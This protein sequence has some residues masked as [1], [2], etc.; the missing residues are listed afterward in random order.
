MSCYLGNVVYLALTVTLINI[1]IHAAML[2]SKR[3]Q[4]FKD[5]GM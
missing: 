4:L 5:D 3:Q 2:A 1:T